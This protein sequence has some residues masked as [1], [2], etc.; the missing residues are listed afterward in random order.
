MWNNRRRN[1]YTLSK[2]SSAKHMTNTKWGTNGSERSGMWSECVTFKNMPS[3][4]VR[5]NAVFLI[6]WNIFF[7]IY[8]PI[9][10]KKNKYNMVKVTCPN[11]IIVKNHVKKWV[12]SILKILIHNSSFWLCKTKSF[13]SP[14][15]NVGLRYCVL[16]IPSSHDTTHH[17][18]CIVNAS[19]LLKP[20][21]WGN[22]RH[23]SVR[24]T[25][26]VFHIFL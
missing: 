13:P 8:N 21:G 2:M 19:L 7:S 1:N 15:L 5:L 11:C 25:G 22:I 26:V 20:V 23:I 3:T 16:V 24:L 6:R 10:I 17:I 4:F 18:L 14:P 9:I 12:K